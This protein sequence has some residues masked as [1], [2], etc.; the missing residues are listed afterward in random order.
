MLTLN[1]YQNGEQLAS[2]T[3]PGH[4]LNMAGW[5]YFKMPAMQIG[6]GLL[7]VELCPEGFDSLGVFELHSKRGFVYKVFNKLGHP[8]KGRDVLKVSFLQ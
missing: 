6:D 2:V 5:T 4:K 7:T 3:L 1:L 8:L